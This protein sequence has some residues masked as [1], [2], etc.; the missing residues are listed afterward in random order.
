[1]KKN[2]KKI[3]FEIVLIPLCIL[4]LYYELLHNHPTISLVFL[5]ITIIITNIENLVKYINE[6]YIYESKKNILKVK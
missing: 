2:N 1:M 3:I 6:V 5:T 4:Y